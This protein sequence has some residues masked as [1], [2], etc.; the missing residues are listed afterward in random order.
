MNSHLADILDH[1]EQAQ[2]VPTE[3][4]PPLLAQLAAAQGAL[5]A[6]LLCSSTV[7]GG[8]Q[9]LQEKDSLLTAEQAAALLNV[10]PRW[11]YRHAKQLP[12]VRR[13]SRKVL[14][15]SEVGIKRWHATKRS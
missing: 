4:I 11:L 9:S 1:P 6:R 7:E 2:E 14:R 13:L 15:F 12:F 10:T 3:A 5:A 8:Q